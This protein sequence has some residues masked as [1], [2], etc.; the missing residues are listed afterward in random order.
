MYPSMVEISKYWLPVIEGTGKR[1]VRSEWAV[2]DMGTVLTYTVCRLG[3][4]V[5]MLSLEGNMS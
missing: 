5:G 1:P 2:S 4:D 3:K